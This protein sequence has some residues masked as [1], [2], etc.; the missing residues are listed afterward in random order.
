M[1]TPHLA[2]VFKDF[3]AWCRSSCVGLNVAGFATAEVLRDAG[4]DVTVFPVRH[5]IDLVHAIDEYNETHDER[6]THVVISAPWLTVYDLKS[7]LYGFPDIHFAILS[8][9]NVGFLQADPEGVRLLRQY[10]ELS[11]GF[12]NLSVGGNSE[13]FAEWMNCAYGENGESDCDIVHLPNLYPIWNACSTT[14]DFGPL[15]IGAFGAVRPYKNFMTAAGAALVLQRW[16]NVP[17]EFHMSAGGEIDDMVAPA[18][19][20]IFEGTDVTLVVHPWRYWDDFINLIGDMDLLMQPS[21]TESFNMITADGILRGVPSVVSTAI[22]W[23]PNCWKA[24]SDDAMDVARVAMD[25]LFDRRY[26]MAGIP[27]LRKH[28]EKALEKWAEFL[29]LRKPTLWERIKNWLTSC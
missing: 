9:S 5:N 26:R 3:A 16:L 19:A 8:H 15:K 7:L 6:L 28:N 22:R 18:I 4:V 1:K 20:Q 24:D 17:V 2:L 21:Y 25:L 12:T 23:A 10:H 11:K 29:G 13:R 27:A 14:W